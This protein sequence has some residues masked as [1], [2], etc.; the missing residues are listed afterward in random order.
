MWLQLSPPWPHDVCLGLARLL[1]RLGQLSV[2]RQVLLEVRSISFLSHAASTLKQ[3]Q[4]LEVLPCCMM[5][6]SCTQDIG[7]NSELP[8][9][10][11]HAAWPDQLSSEHKQG[12]FGAAPVLCR[13]QLRLPAQALDHTLKSTSQTHC[14][15]GCWVGRYRLAGGAADHLILLVLIHAGAI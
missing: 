9:D 3:C 10:T 6:A 5:F 8:P 1:W 4:G 15:T 2:H 13:K 11:L 12:L 14:C 7:S